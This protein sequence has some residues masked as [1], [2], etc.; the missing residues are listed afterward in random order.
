MCRVVGSLAGDISKRKAAMRWLKTLSVVGVLAGLVTVA[1]HNQASAADWHVPYIR[2]P[3]S[4]SLGYARWDGF[5]IGGNVGYSDLNANF[6]N[7]T[8]DLVAYILRNTT[9]E[10]EFAPSKWTTLPTEVTNSVSYGGFAG[11]NLQ[12]GQVILGIDVGYNRMSSLE[13]SALDVTARQVHTSD[14]FVNVVQIDAQSSLKLIDYGTLRGRVGY[15]FGRFLPY[16]L[17]G[18]A[19][20]RFD[21]TRMA[22]VTRSGMDV[23]G[24]G[25]LPYG[26]LTD[27]SID[28]KNN[29]FSPGFVA[30]VGLDV[31]LTPNMFVRAEWEYV[32]FAEVGNITSY[33][34]TG[35]VGLAFRF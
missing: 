31:S 35:R 11:Y 30:G 34:N 23:S 25:G 16:V 8:G 32:D 13:T 5:Q 29:A 17:F 22:T 4:P 27:T 33:V 21:Y 9:V 18:G 28:S 24:G 15:A 3:L 19:V 20:G 1:S 14:G 12:F 2:G 10:N 7:S 26:P 6:G